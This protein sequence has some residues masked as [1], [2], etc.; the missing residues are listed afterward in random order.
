MWWPWR[1]SVF[2]HLAAW[3]W[4]K[5]NN[6]PTCLNLSIPLGCFSQSQTYKRHSITGRSQKLGVSVELSAW[7]EEGVGGLGK[8]STS[9]LLG[10]SSG[11]WNFAMTISFEL[12]FL[13]FFLGYETYPKWNCTINLF[14]EAHWVG[15][16]IAKHSRELEILAATL[17]CWGYVQLAGHDHGPSRFTI[18]RWCL[19]LEHQLPFG[20][21][22]QAAQS[23]LH[24]EDLPLQRKFEWG[25]LLRHF[26]GS[27]E[28]SFDHLQG[29]AFH[30]VSLDRS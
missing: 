26:E 15:W 1:R 4:L 20:L 3:G 28:P 5:S 11:R 27:V 10:R 8:W 19:L 12:T 30:L 22:V 9:E 2:S 21:P 18:P 29:L 17:D 24:H 13:V 7:S 25:N 6:L 23:A 16:A 14:S